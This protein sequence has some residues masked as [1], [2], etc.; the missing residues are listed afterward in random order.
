MKRWSSGTRAAWLRGPWPWLVAAALLL[1]FPLRF[2]SKPVGREMLTL[3]PNPV[4]R[5]NPAL[6]E[7][8][9]LLAT[10]APRIPPGASFTV[11][12]ASREAEM[13]A[14]MLAVGLVPHGRPIPSSYYGV[15]LTAM[16]AEA[17]WVVVVGPAPALPPGLERVARLDGGALYRRRSG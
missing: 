16:G 4:E 2:W 6:G 13:E 15:P 10:V 11:R 7:A 8:W 14:F 1:V 17:E 12:A 5:V 9:Q 3:P